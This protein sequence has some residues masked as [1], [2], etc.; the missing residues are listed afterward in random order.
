MKNFLC[1]QTLN[2]KKIAQLFYFHS[3]AKLVEGK[4]PGHHFWGMTKI[5]Y[6]AWDK[7]GNSASCS[8]KISVKG[9]QPIASAMSV[10]KIVKLLFV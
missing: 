6:M 7:S 5:A 10:K 2:E 8:F 4:S 1:I 3:S 9:K